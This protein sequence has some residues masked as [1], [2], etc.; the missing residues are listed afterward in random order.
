M[1]QMKILGCFYSTLTHLAVV[2]S[3]DT[4]LGKHKNN[5]SFLT[6]TLTLLWTGQIRSGSVFNVINLDKAA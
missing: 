2:E 3:G 4:S 1:G 6:G 5:M